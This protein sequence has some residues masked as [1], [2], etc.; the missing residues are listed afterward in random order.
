MTGTPTPTSGTVKGTKELWMVRVSN[1]EFQLTGEQ[2][3]NLKKKIGS[4]DLGYADFGDFG[5]KIS[6]I[7]CWWLVSRQIANQLEA[8]E[9]NYDL[10]PEERL[11]GRKKLKEIKERFFR[12]DSG[13]DA[14]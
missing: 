10:S 4:G 7:S 9:K 13:L 14:A 11:K 1:E 6:H 2:M 12:S 3:V 5:I 8:P